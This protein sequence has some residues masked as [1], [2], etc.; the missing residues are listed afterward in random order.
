[1]M[2]TR[3]IVVLSLCAVMLSCAFSAMV[4]A[5]DQDVR[6]ERNITTVTQFKSTALQQTM[7][8]G[9]GLNTT[10]AISLP[11][12]MRILSARM[13]ILGLM[14]PGSGYGA[15]TYDFKD[16]SFR[17]WNGTIST[18]SPST[19]PSTYYNN[20][21]GS[22]A[23]GNISSLNGVYESTY[24]SSKFGIYCYHL[25]ELNCSDMPDLSVAN[26][27]WDGIGWS[28]YPVGGGGAW[29]YVWMS[30]SWAQA[31]SYTSG[32]PIQTRTSLYKEFTGPTDL[33]NIRDA[34]GMVY[35]MVISASSAGG[36][37]RLETD[38]VHVNM[39]STLDSY[40]S[41]CYLDIGQDGSHEWSTAGD[42]NTKVRIDDGEGFKGALQA[43]IASKTG[44]VNVTLAFYSLTPGFVKFSNLSINW[45]DNTDPA[46]T[47]PIPSIQFAED[48]GNYVTAFKLS[49]HFSDNG[50]LTYVVSISNANISVTVNPDLSLNFSAVSDFF[51]SG[52]C[53]ISATDTGDDGGAG[54]PDDKTIWSNEFLVSVTPTDDAPIIIDVN[55]EALAGYAVVVDAYEDANLSIRINATDMDGDAVELTTNL[56]KFE[57]EGGYLNYTPLQSDVGIFYIGVAATEVNSSIPEDLL[58]FDTV[59]ITLVV[60]NTNDAP[61]ILQL[62]KGTS[63]LKPEPDGV[64]D[65]TIQEDAVSNFTTIYEDLDGDTCTFSTN[66]TNSRFVLDLVSGNLSFSPL[67]EDVG[68]H[69]ISLTAD[70]GNGG[71]DTIDL[72]VTVL[73]VND[74]PVNKNFTYALDWANATFKA[75]LGTDEDGDTL[76]YLWTFG[77]GITGEGIIANHTYPALNISQ[78]YTVG[79]KLYD[80]HAYSAEA[81]QTILVPAT[82]FDNGTIGF[83]DDDDD[84]ADWNKSLDEIDSDS[85][86]GTAFT[87]SGGML[88]IIVGAVVGILVLVIIVIL[89][90]VVVMRRR[91]GAEAGGGGGAGKLAAENTG[92]ASDPSLLPDPGMQPGLQQGMVSDQSQQQ[93]PGIS[94]PDQSQ[95]PYPQGPAPYGPTQTAYGQ[96][97]PQPGYDPALQPAPGYDQYGQPQVG[98]GQVQQQLPPQPQMQQQYPPQ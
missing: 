16:T 3:T 39:T 98:Q 43:L 94:G 75:N 13:D 35:V 58:L 70:D 90:A 8:F 38:Y 14:K 53:N 24:A 32:S 26:V 84:S 71:T 60:H 56:T 7:V 18:T 34:G 69:I 57:F 96:P 83:D 41:S 2:R 10:V 1:M 4:V 67:Q 88:G 50:P 59:N 76:A 97:Q 20:L 9:P 17:A 15:K 11:G 19:A 87:M 28:N 44:P 25:F 61:K 80:G 72:R 89:I 54:N 65:L 78:N 85:T 73:N 31:G 42:F 46:F 12:S 86:G 55:G 40:P 36:E 68:V 33:A 92:S 48:S 95:A 23:T 66:N 22:K 29:A 52:L 49:D 82:I 79:L 6:G 81:F 63:N 62:K 5:N 21:W 45:T 51:G 47:G 77:D 30:S 37:A 64:V 74:A 91:K 93:T 27:S